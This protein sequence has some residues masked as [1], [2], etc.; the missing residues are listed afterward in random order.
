MKR[1]ADQSTTDSLTVP[2]TT[3][4]QTL[5]TELPTI[6]TALQIVPASKRHK[7]THVQACSNQRVICFDFDMTLTHHHSSGY[8]ISKSNANDPDYTAWNKGGKAKLMGLLDKLKHMRLYIVSRG[9]RDEIDMYLQQEQL[10]TYFVAIK[11][12]QNE[13]ELATGVLGG[14]TE[15]DEKCG[16]DNW[17]TLKTQMLRSILSDECVTDLI[18]LDDTPVNVERAR[19]Y[20][21]SAYLVDPPGLDTTISL[22]TQL[23]IER[24]D[25]HDR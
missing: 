24:G 11:A 19:E 6:S 21:I 1:T 14:G 7:P 17:A 3:E 9:L 2:T 22:L 25:N 5:P 10:R 18:F 8:P 15:D 16:T 20:G 23:V 4:R 13:D 12:A